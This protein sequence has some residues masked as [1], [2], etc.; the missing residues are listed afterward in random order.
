MEKLGSVYFRK[1]SIVFPRDVAR[2][3]VLIF[4]GK[5]PKKQRIFKKKLKKAFDEKV[6]PQ[7]REMS[8]NHG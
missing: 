6:L 7:L 8:G 2:Q 1:N 3:M 5:I 4:N